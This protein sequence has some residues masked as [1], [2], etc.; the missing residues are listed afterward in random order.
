MKKL[1]FLTALLFPVDAR[2]SCHHTVA[3]VG[4]VPCSEEF[5]EQRKR[6][7]QEWLELK[8]SQEQEEK[9]NAEK[10]E[11]EQK[12]PEMLAKT[13]YAITNGQNIPDDV[14]EYVQKI[15]QEE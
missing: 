3:N 10:I 14:M 1:I 2:A 12:A 11:A 4:N 13:I 8:I 5:L 9:R 15:I 7:E 6:D